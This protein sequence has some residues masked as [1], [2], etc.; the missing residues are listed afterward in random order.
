MRVPFLALVPACVLL[1]VACAALRGP[2]AWGDALLALLGGLAAHIAVN[3][4][5]EWDD[6]R[7]GVDLRTERTPFSGGSGTLPAHPEASR[8]ALGIAL[9]ALLV[10]AA[11]GL[12]F[13]LRWGWGLLP[14]GLLGL[15]TI[16]LY[17]RWLTRSPLLCLLA[18]GLGFGPCMVMGTDYALTGSYSAAAGVASLVPF[19]LVSNLL[20]LNQFPDVAADA[21]AGRRHLIIAHGME[22]GV[23]VYGLFLAGAYL[24]LAAGV[25]LGVLPW[26]ALL[27]LLTAPL[28]FAAWQG[29]RRH[30]ANAPAL[31]PAMGQNVLIN[32]ATPALVA[33]GIFL[34][35]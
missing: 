6:F 8:V 28:A 5:N 20:L 12:R 22:A 19:F 31:I 17:T 1:G 15:L 33:L 3:A 9:A 4:L 13:L 34:G 18:P 30:H 24:S 7:S 26:P 27:G 35:R 11:V 29:A 2:I 23:R 32:L 21:A 25:G 10:T 14:L 16:V